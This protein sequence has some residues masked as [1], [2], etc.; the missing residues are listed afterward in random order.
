MF[1]TPCLDLSGMEAFPAVKVPH[2]P[3]VLGLEN[4]GSRL[5]MPPKGIHAA[6]LATSPHINHTKLSYNLKGFS[7]SCSFHINPKLRLKN[8]ST[9]AWLFLSVWPAHKVSDTHSQ[10]QKVVSSFLKLVLQLNPLQLVLPH[11]LTW[12]ASPLPDRTRA[13]SPTRAA[14][15]CA[16]VERACVASRCNEPSTDHG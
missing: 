4:P 10:L 15:H 1:S 16:P 14:S 8:V 7:S 3:S 13:R 2:S 11:K 5:V 6:L 9:W 12:S